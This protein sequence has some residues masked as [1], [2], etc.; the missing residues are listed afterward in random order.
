MDLGDHA[1][2]GAEAARDHHLAVLGERL[3]DGVERLLDG[4]VDE[5]A[6]VDDDEIRVVV[7]RRGDVAFGA[8]LREDA[9][10]IDER[11]RT[12]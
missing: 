10:G 6:G 9:L 12:T 3:A 2:L 1:F 11:L 8:Q 4:G 7:R 5:A